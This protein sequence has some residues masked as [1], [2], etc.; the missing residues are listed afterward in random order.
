MSTVVNP[1][2]A[3]DPKAHSEK[4]EDVHYGVESAPVKLENVEGEKNNLEWAQ[5]LQDAIEAEGVERGQGWRQAFRD[6]PQSIF[7]SFAIS[8]CIIM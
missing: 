7:W 4:T 1:I 3:V 6:Y 5:L 8:L 2:V